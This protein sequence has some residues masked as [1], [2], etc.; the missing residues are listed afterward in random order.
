M[1]EELNKVQVKKAVQALFAYVK[2]KGN[3]DNLVLNENE[4]VS[5]MVTVWNIPKEEKTI[6]ISLPHG[7]R[8]ETSE[9]CLFTKDEPNM[10]AEQTE[11]FYKKLLSQHGITNIT[12]IIPYKALK[13][14]YKPFEAKRRLLSSFDLFLSD[15][16]IRRLLPSHI[17]THFYRTKRVPFSVNLRAKN[18]AQQLN[19]I[20]QGTSLVVNKKGGCYTTRIGHTGMKVDD[21]VENVMAAFSVI[22]EKIPKKW[23]NLKIIHLKSETSVA[24]PIYNSCIANLD[25]LDQQAEPLGKG[26][27]KG[28]QKGKKGKSKKERKV[29][30]QKPA[31][32]ELTAEVNTPA[33]DELEKEQKEKGEASTLKK[34]KQKVAE[35]EEEI[36][37]LVPIET[38]VLTK[39][40]K[41][42]G[43][44][45]GKSKKECK[46][47]G[48]KP[49]G[50]ELTAEVNTP[51]KDELEKE[52]K[53]KGEAS[54]LKK[55]KQK[56]AENEEEIP[57]LVPIETPVLTKRQK[58]QKTPKGNKTPMKEAVEQS[59]TETPVSKKNEKGSV[60][61]TPIQ[62]TPKTKR[63][64]AVDEA[65]LQTSKK[66]KSPKADTEKENGHLFENN[67]KK[68]P[69][70]PGPRLLASKA[71]KLTKSAK[72]AHQAPQQKRK[73]LKVL[74]SA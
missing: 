64:V 70:K 1:A 8:P 71:E 15:D 61:M 69:K 25:E 33:K 35:N 40:Q 19:R 16:R 7:I 68:T 73:N 46:V 39:R 66:A 4:K 23:R 72:R 48:Q 63:K 49:A 10:T 9:V 55:S 51:A 5:M 41:L 34:S 30:G 52:Q 54:T 6:K 11:K 44:Q 13:S 62:K 3:V 37:R 20:I 26:V 57:R 18:L 45:K 28:K 47:E 14:E 59:Y 53:E 2:S 74:H 32:P 12:Q 50:P 24:L 56:V 36:P 27:K 60:Q 22:A 42:Q 67:Q 31:G 65:E 38:P 21:V 58:L 29:E 43:K 17:G